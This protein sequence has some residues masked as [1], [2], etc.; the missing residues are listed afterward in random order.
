MLAEKLNV[1]FIEVSAKEDTN[2][3]KLFSIFGKI[4][5]NKIEKKLK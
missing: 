4:V 1:P 3:Q 5:K 2:I